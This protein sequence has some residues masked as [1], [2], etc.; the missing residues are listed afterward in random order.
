MATIR[1]RTYPMSIVESIVT[2]HFRLTA[3]DNELFDQARRCVCNAFDA[4]ED[5]TNRIIVA[6]HAAFTLG[7][8]EEGVL[9]LPTAPVKSVT[10]VRYLASNGE[11][12][13]IDTKDYELVGDCRSAELVFNEVV[14][15]TRFRVNAECGFDDYADE[16]DKSEYAMPGAIEQAVALMAQTFLD[17]EALSGAT[18]LA[19]HN[20]LNPW[21][22]YPYGG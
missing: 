10:E 15:A 14:A 1:N 20:M 17:G 3:D 18:E 22:I 13:T 8:A 5:Y 11:W 4:A 21:R 12:H 9:R 16:A 6:C 7:E 19:A 2:R